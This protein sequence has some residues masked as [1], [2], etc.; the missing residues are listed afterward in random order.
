MNLLS[1]Q[2]IKKV[3]YEFCTD[4]TFLLQFYLEDQ[5]IC[6]FFI[7]YG[8]FDKGIFAGREKITVDNFY[9]YSTSLLDHFIKNN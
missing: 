7:R 6:G 3:K 2:A 9:K 5:A 8:E 4:E 1:W